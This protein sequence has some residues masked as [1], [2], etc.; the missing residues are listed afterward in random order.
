[1][2]KYDRISGLIW[3]VLGGGMAIEE[4]SVWV[5]FIVP[6]LVLCHFG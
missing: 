5:K 6:E 2:R 4:I 1:M 3:F